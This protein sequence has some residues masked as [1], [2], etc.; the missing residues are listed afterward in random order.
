MNRHRDETAASAAEY[1]LVIA[2]IA[3][4][5]AV[6]VW[7]FGGTVRELFTDTCDQVDTQVTETLT[8]S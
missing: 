2:G 1:A 3:A 8:C 7:A 5:I 6:A 4:V